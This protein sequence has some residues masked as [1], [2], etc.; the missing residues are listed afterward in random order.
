MTYT[1][2]FCV[3]YSVSMFLLP[4][5]LS[6]G[7]L[8]VVAAGQQV[9]KGQILAQLAH[10][11]EV[12]INLSVALG[13][14]IR[15]VK[16]YIT[17]GDGQDV[18]KGDVLARKKGAF[19]FSAEQIVSEVEGKVA[20]YYMDSGELVIYPKIPST[21][22]YQESINSPIDG[23]VTICDN[24]KIVIQTT[25]PVIVAHDGFGQITSAEVHV[26]NANPNDEVPF[27]ALDIST[28]D[29]ILI[30]GQFTREGIVK[31]IGMGAQGI[32]VRSLS[33]EDREYVSQKYSLPILIVNE[34]EYTQ[35]VSL[36][37]KTIYI[38]GLSKSIVI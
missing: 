3:C 7:Y 21:K 4:I 1:S 38:D 27:F 16:K 33:N 24:E 29:K 22:T 9:T 34:P 6:S 36:S 13:V 2:V 5:I 10:H 14:P 28:R 17:V 25:A 20:G 30:G 15:S 12:R 35:L 37:G 26:L 18:K 31:A 8:P 32:I 23:V 11:P 19:S